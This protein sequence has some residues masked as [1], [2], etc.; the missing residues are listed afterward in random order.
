V[1]LVNRGD[2]TF[3]DETA[4]R[5]EPLDRSVWAPHFEMRDINRDGAKDLLSFPWDP[6]QPDP[7]L[8]L[9]DGHGSFRRESFSPGLEGG[10]LY[11]A[12]IDLEGDGGHDLLL[13]LTFPPD[14]VFVVRDL[15]CHK[16]D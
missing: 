3:R 5:M 7:I 9:N 1:A 13:T 8:F 6:D 12:F 10:D 15:G 16:G 14:R 2:G 11:F 4:A